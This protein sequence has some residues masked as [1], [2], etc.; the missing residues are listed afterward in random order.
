MATDIVNAF[1][2]M[3]LMGIQERVLDSAKNDLKGEKLDEESWNRSLARRLLP[4][5]FRHRDHPVEHSCFYVQPYLCISKANSAHSLSELLYDLFDKHATSAELRSLHHEG[6]QRFFSIG[7]YISYALE[8]DDEFTASN[9]V[10]FVLA[11]D[12]S[13]FV[14]PRRNDLAL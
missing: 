7:A 11:G 8:V 9:V 4:K 5:C 13:Q 1:E 14:G 12:L 6:V 10:C 3:H 2:G